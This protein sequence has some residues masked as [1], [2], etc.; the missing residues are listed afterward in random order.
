MR[1]DPHPLFLYG[2]VF[3]EK[4]GDRNFTSDPADDLDSYEM[5]D[6]SYE[7]FGE[8]DG[9]E[10]EDDLLKGM[11][12]LNDIDNAE[13]MEIPVREVKKSKPAKKAKKPVSSPKSSSSSIRE[14]NSSVSG[15]S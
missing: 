8:E 1:G 5:E 13:T 12:F 14:S 3:D 6:D 11:D 10:D 7:D 15:S 2:G 9:Y 4:P